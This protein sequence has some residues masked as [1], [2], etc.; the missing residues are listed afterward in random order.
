VFA[1]EGIE[2]VLTPPQAPNANA[3]A[4]RW[5]RTI[6]E[7]CLGHLLIFGECHLL[8]VRKEY[9]RTTTTPGPIRGLSSKRPF[10]LLPLCRRN[11][12]AD[13]MSWMA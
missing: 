9:S 4:E 11:K 5:V 3:F 12:S 13:A 10:H 8:R 1:S 2:M 7:E 6:R